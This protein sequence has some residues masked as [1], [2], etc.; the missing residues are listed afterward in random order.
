MSLQSG[1]DNGK[2]PT[3]FE[4]HPMFWPTVWVLL[5]IAMI[6]GGV[7][8]SFLMMLAGQTGK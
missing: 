6:I 8:W 3:F 1:C 5:C 2:P 4:D 7:L